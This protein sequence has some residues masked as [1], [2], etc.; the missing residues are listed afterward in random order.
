[1]MK[2][3]FYLMLAC[4]CLLSFIVSFGLCLTLLFL[5]FTIIMIYY[6]IFQ[7][8]GEALRPFTKELALEIAVRK[9]Y[10]CDEPKSGD[11]CS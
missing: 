2:N 5:I 7:K 4:S 6:G 8:N 11:T 1:M 10:E 9:K 3:P